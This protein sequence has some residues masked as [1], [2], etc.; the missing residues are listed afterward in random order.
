MQKAQKARNKILRAFC[1]CAM[2]KKKEQQLQ[3]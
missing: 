3:K 2:I 1:V